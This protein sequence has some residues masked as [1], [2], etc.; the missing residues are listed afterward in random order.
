MILAFLMI[1]AQIGDLPDGALGPEE[2]HHKDGGRSYTG[3]FGPDE[4]EYTFLPIWIRIDLSGASVTVRNRALQAS[5]CNLPASP[6]KAERLLCAIT[7]AGVCN[8]SWVKHDSSHKY[9]AYVL[10]PWKKAKK[11]KGCIADGSCNPGGRISALAGT[12][13]D[14]RILPACSN[15][16]DSCGATPPFKFAG[17]DVNKDVPEP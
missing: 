1:F 10:L 7:A 3:G 15:Y 11:L 16:F 2:L 14:V 5:Q 17:I 12:W 8:G 13:D 6:T 4:D 9:I